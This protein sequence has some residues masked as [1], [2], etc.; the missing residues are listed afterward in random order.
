MAF[1]FYSFID[2]MTKAAEDKVKDVMA[3]KLE[4]VLG[5]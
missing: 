4:I 5:N 3:G 1:E 2:V